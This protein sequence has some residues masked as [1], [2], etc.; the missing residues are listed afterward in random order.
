MFHSE[1]FYIRNKY[2][3]LWGQ[4]EKYST[5]SQKGCRNRFPNCINQDINCQPGGQ[6]TSKCQCFNT[7]FMFCSAQA[8]F[9]VFSSKVSQGQL[10][11]CA[12]TNL[13]LQGYPRII[14]PAYRAQVG[15]GMVACEGKAR[16][17]LN[18]LGLQVTHITFIYVPLTRTGHV[19][20]PRCK[21]NGSCGFPGLQE[22]N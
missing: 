17:I 2:R 1:K 20:P 12:H 14:Q 9:L 3:V 16:H 18:N 13:A 15:L 4:I 11:R 7:I 21:R 19:A 6:T 8:D 22:E 5:K 10:L